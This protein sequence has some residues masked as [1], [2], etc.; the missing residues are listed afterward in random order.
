MVQREKTASSRISVII[1]T[2]NEENYIGDLLHDLSQQSRKPNEIIVVDGHSR[3]KTADVVRQFPFTALVR[4]YPSALGP[5]RNFGAEQATGEILIFLE[6]DVRLRQDFLEKT[7]RQ[8]VDRKLDIASPFLWPHRSTKLIRCFYI[9][10]N[11]AMLFLQRIHPTGS[12]TCLVVQRKKF[13]RSGGF[14][15]I[16]FD[17]LDL[18]LRMAKLSRY[19]ILH[20]VALVSDRRFRAQGTWQLVRIFLAAFIYSVLRQQE[21]INAIPYRYGHYEKPPASQN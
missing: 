10:Y 11:G 6:A 14:A 18:I 13:L 4:N 15:N 17:D 5:D 20:T 21:R 2:L 3:D 8:F 16:K 1:P 12:T 7:V 19:G 9:F